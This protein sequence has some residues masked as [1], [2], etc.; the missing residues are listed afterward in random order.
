MYKVNENSYKKSIYEGE[1]YY[2]V[3]WSSYLKC[4]K[5]DILKK[6]PKMPGIFVV[7]YK[8][9][10]NR[11]VPFYLSYAWVNSIMYALSSVLSDVADHDAKIKEILE[12][13]KCYYKY[14][15][16][17]SYRD[18]LDMYQ[19]YKTYYESRNTYFIK[20]ELEPDS[21]RYKNVF[22]QDYSELV[23]KK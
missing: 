9:K 12:D 10:G 21:G 17:E 19:Y 4:I 20:K 2:I 16:I 15:I 3:R 23:K 5:Y 22:V 18:M 6:I 14:V 11:L 1:A 13:E 7:F 8:T